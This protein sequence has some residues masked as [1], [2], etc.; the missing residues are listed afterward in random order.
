MNKEEIEKKVKD[1]L[2]QKQSMMMDFP[3]IMIN[4]V[5]THQNKMAQLDGAIEILNQELKKI[6]EE[7]KE[8]SAKIDE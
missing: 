1:L 6:K 7:E 3:N 4:V 5:L 8:K 2:G